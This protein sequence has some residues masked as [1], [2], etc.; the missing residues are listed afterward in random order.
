V[1]APRDATGRYVAAEPLAQ[2]DGWTAS[3]AA[4]C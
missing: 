4:A 2:L 1:T 3:E